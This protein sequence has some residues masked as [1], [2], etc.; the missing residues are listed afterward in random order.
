MEEYAAFLDGDRLYSGKCKDQAFITYVS[1]QCYSSIEMDLPEDK[2]YTVELI[3]VW[4][5]TRSIIMENASGKTKIKLPGK[6]GMAVLAKS[7]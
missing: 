4:N 7:F 1:K 6:V 3:D 5:M 2:N